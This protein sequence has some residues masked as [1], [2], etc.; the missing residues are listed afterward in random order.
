MMMRRLK[1]SQHGFSLVEALVAFL[2]ISVGML[3]I[4]SLQTVSLRAGSTAAMRSIAVIKAGEII[5]RM[6][7]NPTQVLSYAVATGAT[8][9]DNNCTDIGSVS[10]CS[11][12]ELAADDI[13]HWLRDL[14]AAMPNN[15]AAD[16]SITVTPPGA[17]D[18]LSVV[19]VTI[20][21]SERAT[22]SQALSA[23]SYSL[24]AE[25]CGA[26]KC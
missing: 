22:D 14:K 26:L 16:A 5:E 21:W 23:Q 12:A 19:T 3:G 1:K 11:P 10:A 18:A 20:N 17:T 8:G 13:Y 2:V 4:A 24:T 25:I 15:G 6:R 7:A 9:T